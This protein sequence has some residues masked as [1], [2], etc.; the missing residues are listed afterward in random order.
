MRERV[1]LLVLCI[2][3]RCGVVSFPLDIHFFSL[4]F[5][6]PKGKTS[7]YRS[8]NEWINDDATTM[9]GGGWWGAVAGIAGGRR[10]QKQTHS[11][12]PWGGVLCGVWCGQVPL[13]DE[14][15][16]LGEVLQR[17]AGAAGNG[18]Q[19]VFGY[20]DLQLGLGGDALVEAAEQ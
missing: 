9:P 2:G 19:G 7:E 18:A 6:F 4:I 8:N 1:V 13:A 16:E 20:V 3:R 15:G 5:P 12:P 17:D 14:E 11:T 10:V